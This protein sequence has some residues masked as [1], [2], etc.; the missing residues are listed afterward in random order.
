MDFRKVSFEWQNSKR[1]N[2]E[3][4]SSEIDSLDKKRPHGHFWMKKISD[5]NSW[6]QIG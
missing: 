3:E 5:D 4:K 2:F 6:S 1:D